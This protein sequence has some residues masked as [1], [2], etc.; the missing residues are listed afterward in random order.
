MIKGMEKT[1]INRRNI[2]LSSV[3]AALISV[4][5]GITIPIGPVP[6][7]LQVFFILL[8]LSLAGPKYGTISVLIYILLGA[9]GIPVFAGYNGG[10]AI[11]L[12]PTGGYLFGF[13]VA[14]FVGGIISGKRKKDKQMEIVFLSLGML[15]AISVIYLIGFTWLKFSLGISF[16]DAFTVGVLPFIP[17]DILKMAF[18]FPIAL[19][20]RG[21]LKTL[22][23]YNEWQ[24][25]S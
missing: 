7:T 16:K 6:I 2:A 21:E 3:L 9:I 22:P 5:A 1:S 17:I 10:I 8:I 19:R 24:I 25:Q 4:T 15:V 20:L 23:I 12:G 14:V 18:V 11:L 13:S